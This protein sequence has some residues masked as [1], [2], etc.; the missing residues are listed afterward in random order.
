MSQPGHHPNSAVVLATIDHAVTETCSSPP[1]LGWPRDT[2]HIVPCFDP[3]RR[4]SH[5]PSLTAARYYERKARRRSA[6][7]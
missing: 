2:C 6:S 7:C 4:S 5:R 3:L 1:G